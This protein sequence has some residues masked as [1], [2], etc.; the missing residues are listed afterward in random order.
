[1][2]E[3]TVS[4]AIATLNRCDDLRATLLDLQ[5]LD[6]APLE[7][8]VCLDGCAD[9]SREMVAEFPFVAVIENERPSGS[10]Y[11]RDRLFRMAQ[12]DLIVS[13]DDD[14]SPMQTDFVARLADLASAHPE[15]GVFAFEEVRPE[16]RDDRPF[17]S[18]SGA[19]YVASYANC[20]GAVRTNLYKSAEGYPAIFFHMYEEPDFCLQTYAN[21]FAVLYE[22]AIKILHRYSHVGRNMIG[23][24][25]QHA[26]NELLSVIIRCPFPHVLWVAAYRVARQFI[27]A[28]SK[29]L[30]WVV[31]EPVWWWKTANDLS[32]ALKDRKPVPWPVYWQWMRLARNPIPVVENQLASKF[33][34]VTARLK[35][36]QQ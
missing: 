18:L 14:S 21:Q 15:A 1:M 9:G 12:G 17:G 24:H 8:L 19:A 25:H 10:V 32:R 22:P 11:S 16:G 4:V 29:G 20:A 26:R 34:N 27:Y 35:L 7:I 33:P 36:F 30:V 28:A 3:L 13:L 5:K 2:T 6:P 31:R 23:R